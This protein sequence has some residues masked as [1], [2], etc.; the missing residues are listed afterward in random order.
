MAAR[1]GLAAILR[2]GRRKRRPPQDE[3]LNSWNTEE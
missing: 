2:D 3:V 1:H